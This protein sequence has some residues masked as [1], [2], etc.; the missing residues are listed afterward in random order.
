[1]FASQSQAAR[2]LL[3][4]A[5][6][7]F[8]VG[9]APEAEAQSAKVGSIAAFVGEV[10]IVRQESRISAVAGAELRE[11][12][13][14]VTGKGAWA[15]IALADGSQLAMGGGS[16]LALNEYVVDEA[17]VRKSGVF[18]LVVGIIRAFVS[19]GNG[20]FVIDTQ[21]AVA[22]ARSTEFIVEAAEGETAVFVNEGL[23]VV[24]GVGRAL[25]E[26]VELGPTEGTDVERGR[27]P[28]SPRIWG[29]ERVDSAL[30]RTQRPQ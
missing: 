1:M 6:F 30:E 20:S 9:P 29:P 24:R 12:D 22:S 26:S 15:S 14:L 23:V 25:R 19:G 17:R 2:A 27:A 21:A 11:R 4:C 28:A 5:V 7:L 18:S 10:E 16:R 13:V 3:F 8:A